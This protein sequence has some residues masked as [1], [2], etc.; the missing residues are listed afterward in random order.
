MTRKNSQ[1]RTKNTGLIEKILI[2][3]KVTRILPV[4]LLLMTACAPK[5]R[6]IEFPLVEAANTE[7]AVIEKVE[8]TDSLT[9]LHIRG[10]HI[11]GYWI[12]LAK[13]AH[14]VAEGVSYEMVGAEGIIPRKK[15]TMPEDGDS[16]FVL[17]FQPLPMNTEKFDFTEGS[18]DG[19]WNLLDVNLTGKRVSPYKK[20]MPGHV[21]PTSDKKTDIPGFVYDL[22]ETTVNVHFLGYKPSYGNGFT[23]YVCSITGVQDEY[24]LQVNPDTG[25]ASVTFQQYGTVSGFLLKNSLLFGEFNVAPGET[26]DFYCDLAYMDYVTSAQKKK[27]GL[28]DAIKPLFTDGSVYDELNNVPYHNVMVGDV[29]A[30]T[31]KTPEI[32][33]FSADDYADLVIKEYKA[34]IDSLE[35]MNL[36]PMTKSKLKA[37][38]ALECIRDAKN[39][40]RW[41]AISFR[42]ASDPSVN[43]S[44]NPDLMTDQHIE[45]ITDNL[46]L[47]DPMLLLSEKCGYLSLLKIDM[48]NKEKYGNVRYIMPLINN[49]SMARKGVLTEE[50]LEEMKKWDEPFFHRMCEDIQTRTC[51]LIES[52]S[53]KYEKTPAVSVDKLFEAIIAPHKGK[54][55]VVDFWN[56]WCGPCR[57]ALKINEPYKSGELASDNIV[58]IYIADESSPID[59]YLEMIPDIKGIHYRVNDMEAEQ[60]KTR[61]F[62]LDGIPSYVLVQK[63]GSYALSNEFR[64]HNLMV[65]TLKKL[66]E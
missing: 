61:D 1:S 48:D 50:A 24:Q 57:R 15:L 36:H 25:I 13:G 12:R 21:K 52:S 33:T 65:K 29:F 41:K 20:G 35:K 44:F 47:L 45:R 34:A 64:N 53:D 26:V 39:E 62:N 4:L 14:L 8:M 7:N 31:M 27:G 59:D 18:Q 60:L 66:V 54:V 9:S 32:Y 22:G 55:V 16:L 30:S 46:D 42:R 23:M 5:H 63:D 10:Y 37:E 11:P 56:T 49:V 58:W 40:S 51:Q 3:M 6:I 28:L 17:H 38:I 43:S 19:D 2:A